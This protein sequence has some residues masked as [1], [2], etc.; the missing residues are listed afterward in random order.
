MSLS[1]HVKNIMI[2][3]N[4]IEMYFPILIFYFL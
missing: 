4:R 1:I 3:M 2:E